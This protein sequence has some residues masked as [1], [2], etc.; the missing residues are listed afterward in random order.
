MLRSIITKI[1]RNAPTHSIGRETVRGLPPAQK[2]DGGYSER[3]RYIKVEGQQWGHTIS[4]WADLAAAVGA[5][6]IQWVYF[7]FILVHVVQGVVADSKTAMKLHRY[8]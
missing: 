4:S 1:N 5:V 3:H 8:L 2:I 7:K 6:Y